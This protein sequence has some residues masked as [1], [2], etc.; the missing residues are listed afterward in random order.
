MRTVKY[1]GLTMFYVGIAVFFTRQFKPEFIAQIDGFYIDLMWPI[2][3]IIYGVA[4]YSLER[5]NKSTKE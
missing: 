2:G 1:I 4:M 3:L 5:N